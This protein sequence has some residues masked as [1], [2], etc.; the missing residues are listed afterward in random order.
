M[1]ISST[2]QV[3]RSQPEPRPTLGPKGVSA[4]QTVSPVNSQKSS[5]SAFFQRQSAERRTEAQ[6]KHAPQSQI[7]VA[8][9]KPESNSSSSSAQQATIVADGQLLNMYG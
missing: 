7:K 3:P 2:T 6:A 5:G 1:S 9:H 4:A 8:P